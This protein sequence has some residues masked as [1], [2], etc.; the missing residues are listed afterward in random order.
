VENVKSLLGKRIRDLRKQRCL[1]QEGLGWK[2]ELHLTYIGAIE[3]GEK[4]CSIVTLEKIAKGLE[5]TIR[6]LFDPPFHETD[7]GKIKKEI[8]QEINRLSSQKLV[9]LREMLKLMDMK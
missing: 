1:S 7:I 2:S 3:R 6:D 9:I 4:N 5:I 8:N